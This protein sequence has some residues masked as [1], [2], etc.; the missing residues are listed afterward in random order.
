METRFLSLAVTVG[1]AGCSQSQNSLRYAELIF[2]ITLV[3]VF[4]RDL[5][6]QEGL[7]IGF[8]GGRCGGEGRK[9][10]A[11]DSTDSSPGSRLWS[12]SYWTSL[13][14]SAAVSL[15]LLFQW[16]RVQR[17]PVKYFP[18][19]TPSNPAP[20]WLTDKRHWMM[21]SFVLLTLP[22]AASTFPRACCSICNCFRYGE[23]R[24]LETEF[25][26]LILIF[27][28]V[29]YINIQAEGKH[30]WRMLPANRK[31]VR[32]A[33]QRGSQRSVKGCDV[34]S[35]LCMGWLCFQFSIASTEQPRGN[36]ESL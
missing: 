29:V 12:W 4:W 28:W 27:A 5:H 34:S 2:W 23:I 18:P 36:T 35:C 31:H 32:L 10:K 7:L 1:N 24:W 20:V 22:K 17:F 16:E 21:E 30:P 19:P 13:V 14:S 8:F 11:R 26:C 25:L 6:H 15:Y 33:P 3:T 9:H